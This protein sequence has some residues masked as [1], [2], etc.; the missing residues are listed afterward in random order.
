MYVGARHLG[1]WE[2]FQQQDDGPHGHELN[3]FFLFYIIANL[4]SNMLTTHRK[5]I[6]SELCVLCASSVKRLYSLNNSKCLKLNALYVLN[7]MLKINDDVGDDDE[8]II[9]ERQYFAGAVVNMW[10]FLWRRRWP[11]AKTWSRQT[12]VQNVYLQRHHAPR[13]ATRFS[14][15]PRNSSG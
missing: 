11:F 15:Q 14:H 1:F 10:A 6:R 8:H 4:E 13:Y 2:F 9:N 3:N 12:A 5:E 7:T